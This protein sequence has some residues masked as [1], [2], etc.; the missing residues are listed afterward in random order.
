MCACTSVCTLNVHPADAS[1]PDPIHAHTH[2]QHR[3]RSYRSGCGRP[4]G[5]AAALLGVPPVR[6]SLLGSLSFSSLRLLTL[7]LRCDPSASSAPSARA[8][9]KASRCETTRFRFSSWMPF[10]VK[11]VQRRCNNCVSSLLIICS[12]TFV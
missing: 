2:T 7:L 3:S 9:C 12:I 1:P 5:P 11:L 8:H 6:L 4:A 10:K